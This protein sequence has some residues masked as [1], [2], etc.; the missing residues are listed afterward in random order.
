MATRATDDVNPYLGNGVQRAQSGLS[1]ATNPRPPKMGA[2]V[3]P[4]HGRHPTGIYIQKLTDSSKGSG[5]SCAKRLS[6]DFP[7]SDEYFDLVR[8]EFVGNAGTFNWEGPILDSDETNLQLKAAELEPG[9][10]PIAKLLERRRLDSAAESGGRGQ[11]QNG[12]LSVHRIL[13]AQ[14]CR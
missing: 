6:G 12:N 7:Y 3:R 4:S 9:H 11:E 10:R 8:I 13:Y 5:T 14:C 2:Q 1:C